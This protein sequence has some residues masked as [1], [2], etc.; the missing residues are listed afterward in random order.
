[1]TSGLPENGAITVSLSELMELAGF[2]ASGHYRAL[3]RQS[4]A[5][6][7]TANFEI[8]GGW[9][10]HPNRRW[11]TTT[12]HFIE[13][14]TYTHQGEAGVFDERT[15][16]E[17]RLASQLVASMRSGYTKPLNM[18]FMKSLSRPKTRILFR[19]LDAIRHDPEE[20]EH[21][22]DTFETSLVEWADQCKISSVR[23][24][25]MHRALASP[26]EELIRRG[27]L[28]EV[29]YSGRGQR[30]R[31]FYEF[32]PSFTQIDAS[33][34]ARFRGHGVT[35]GV[36]RALAQ[37]YNITLLL[38][39]I[40]QFE[41]LLESRQLVVKKSAAAALVHLIKNPDQYEA[42]ARKTG[43]VRVNS[44]M[45]EDKA[46]RKAEGPP[47]PESALE[48]W[49]ATMSP[50]ERGDH[51]SRQLR[52]LLGSRLS[53]LELDHLRFRA[54]TGELDVTAV[55]RDALRHT[56][57]RRIDGFLLSLRASLRDVGQ[58]I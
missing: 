13:S 2:H 28:R 49:V 40:E 47:A 52:L 45:A 57:E 36:S 3:T 25:D 7:S 44:R 56:S 55:L 24:Q 54:V 11:I 34:L 19:L 38:T 6:L 22:S 5:R 9:R 58:P 21:T 10:D 43:D 27:Y 1:M 39:R 41:D 51:L 53:A 33:L 4:L 23:M 17:I 30:Q 20:P 35:D 18:T 16:M 29:T 14:L 12:F 37:T 48:D 26:H 32:A 46:R 42:P 15:T 8:N 50:S 31:V